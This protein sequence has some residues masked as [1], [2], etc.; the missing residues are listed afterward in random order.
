[1]AYIGGVFLSRN[2]A[3][4]GGGTSNTSGGTA[5]WQF[6]QKAY[7]AGS[8][9]QQEIFMPD[10]DK[11][12]VQV[13]AA[14]A[15]VTVEGTCDPPDVVIAGAAVWKAVSTGLTDVTASTVSELAEGFTAIRVNKETTATAAFSVR[16]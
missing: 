1:M 15:K 5:P 9:L 11:V 10:F 14:V 6:Y 2:P 3:S 16:C 7:A 12:R 4:G 8:T 13:T